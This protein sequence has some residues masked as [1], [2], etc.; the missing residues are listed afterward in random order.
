MGFLGSCHLSYQSIVQFQ[1]RGKSETH[2]ETERSLS[3]EILTFLLSGLWPA[4]LTRHGYCPFCAYA[5]S[6]HTN[7]L[8]F[9]TCHIFIQLYPSIC[10][11]AS[12][13]AL[14]LST[15]EIR[16]LLITPNKQ[17]KTLPQTESV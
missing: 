16:K 10:H 5:P 1:E 4:H 12:L 15:E 14:S 7:Q 9:V 8:Y 13:L 11:C 6:L 2:H 3:R 17:V